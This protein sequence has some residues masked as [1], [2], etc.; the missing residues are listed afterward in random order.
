MISRTT[1][2]ASAELE[3]STYSGPICPAD[4]RAKKSENQNQTNWRYYNDD[5][6]WTEGKFDLIDDCHPKG[7]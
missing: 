1:M 7:H 3:I 4:P 5:N 2:G 6:K